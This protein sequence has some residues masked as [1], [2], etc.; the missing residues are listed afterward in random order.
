[1][2]EIVTPDVRTLDRTHAA[3][4]IESIT[5]LA[6]PEPRCTVKIH[7]NTRTIA[8]RAFQDYDPGF[9]VDLDLN[10]VEVVEKMAFDSVGF[11]EIHFGTKLHTVGDAAFGG[12]E[13]LDVVLPDTLHTVG[14]LAFFGTGDLEFVLKIPRAMKVIPEEAFGG[15]HAKKV[16]FHDQVALV[17]KKAFEGAEVKELVFEGRGYYID[18]EAFADS[19]VET[20]NL[21]HAANIG[22]FAFSNCGLLR[23][24]WL[25]RIPMLRGALFDRIRPKIL[26]IPDEL[27]SLDYDGIQV[28]GD[29]VRAGR[30]FDGTGLI[31]G[32]DAQIDRLFA[33][34]PIA[35]KK[36][37]CE[38]RFRDGVQTIGEWAVE[39]KRNK[40]L[41]L[42]WEAIAMHPDPPKPLRWVFNA[43]PVEDRRRIIADP[44][45]P[46]KLRQEAAEKAI[47]ATQFFRLLDAASA[48]RVDRET[49]ALRA[50]GDDTTIPGFLAGDR[51]EHRELVALTLS[52][53]TAR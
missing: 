48:D 10:N 13:I 17:G 26:V 7:P 6:R 25:P 20:A 1:M 45:F 51:P 2:E 5:R 21:T 43:F 12:S 32:T 49:A 4:V 41:G 36:V 29:E 47:L 37:V 34:E 52:K 14:K 28:S 16:V 39:M 19:E 30:T 40:D 15:I 11:T 31:V 44:R 9:D 33:H 38:T 53:F 42:W 3:G 23:D 22:Q 46:P 27:V 35:A 24:L 50:A 18:N 8:E